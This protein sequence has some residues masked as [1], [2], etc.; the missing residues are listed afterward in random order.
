MTYNVPLILDHDAH[1]R[2]PVLKTLYLEDCTTDLQH[3]DSILS[4]PAVLPHLKFLTLN[5]TSARIFHPDTLH[6]TSDLNT[7]C[8]SMN[9]TGGH[10]HIPSI[11]DLQHLLGQEAD[12]SSDEP[13]ATPGI[14]RPTWT[15]DWNLPQLNELVMTAEHAFCF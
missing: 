3:S 5:G 4:W 15:W 2:C 8:I 10:Y 14:P 6:I 7:L 1:S 13:G 9:R 12:E 11:Q